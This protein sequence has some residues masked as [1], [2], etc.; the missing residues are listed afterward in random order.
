MRHEYW[1]GANNFRDRIAPKAASSLESEDGLM[2]DDP[3]AKQVDPEVRFWLN[4]AAFEGSAA[5]CWI[6]YTGNQ[7]FPMIPFSLSVSA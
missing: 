4:V 3:D 2:L 5:A 7:A 1:A 6:P